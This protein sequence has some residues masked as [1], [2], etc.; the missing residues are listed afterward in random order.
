MHAITYDLYQFHFLPSHHFLFSSIFSPPQLPCAASAFNVLLNAAVGAGK[1]GVVTQILG[2]MQAGSV[3]VDPGVLASVMSQGAPAREEEAAPAP[4]APAE[5]ADAPAPV[6][7]AS[8]PRYASITEANAELESRLEALDL[9]GMVDHLRR[10]RDSGLQADEAT[11]R[12][13]IR[14]AVRANQPHLAVQLCS[15]AHSSGV[16]RRY[17]LPHEPSGPLINLRAAD[18]ELA[19]TV[20]LTW[21]SLLAQLPEAR[22]AAQ[23][24]T[25][26]II[27]GH[28]P[29]DAEVQDAIRAMLTSGEP[30]V[31]AFR[32]LV[33][34]SL[35]ANSISA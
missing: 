12:L 19:A 28:E 24:D 27:G 5:E 17:F 33:P 9:H 10:V 4:A 13:L 2:A 6:S 8:S 18:R 3:A 11:Y 26:S 29:A 35:P 31:E 32:G 14:S 15:Q 23:G 30:P 20:V 25:L 1:Y 21:L 7:G 16:L 22:A 34:V